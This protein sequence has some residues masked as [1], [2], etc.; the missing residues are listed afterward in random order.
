MPGECIVRVGT[1]GEQMFLLQHGTVDV[2][3]PNGQ[4][5]ARLEDGSFFGGEYKRKVQV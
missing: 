2:I 4:V 5:A 3:L 1:P